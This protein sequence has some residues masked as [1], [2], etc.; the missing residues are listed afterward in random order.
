MSK[1]LFFEERERELS[2]LMYNV[3]EIQL[4]EAEQEQKEKE[5]EDEERSVQ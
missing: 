3:F 4:L 2:A 1:Q 5:E